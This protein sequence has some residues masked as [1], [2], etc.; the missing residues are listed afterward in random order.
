MNEAWQIP[1]TNSV[2]TTLHDHVARALVG[3]RL[4][5]LGVLAPRAH[6]VRITLAGLAFTTTVR[7]VD[8][9]HGLAAHGRADA[10]PALR[11]GLAVHA[12]VVLVVGHLANRGAAVDVHLAALARLQAQQRV[13]AFARGERGRGAG[14]AHHL[15]AL[16]GLELDVV[17]DR[18]D[19]D[20]AQ[21]H[22]VA[23]LDRRIRARAHFVAGGHAL[24]GEDVTALA[25]GVLHQRDVAGAVRIVLDAL[26]HALD[27]VLV[28]TEVDDAVLLLR[29]GALVA[30][31]DAA[32][33]VTARVL[34]LLL[35]QRLVRAALPE[36]R[37]VELDAEARARRSRLHLDD[38]HV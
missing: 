11:A 7:V 29:A 14:A 20:V 24:G 2:L 8:G 23:G 12:Q 25:V 21:L 31:R 22:A 10:Q 35:G 3:T 28:A 26:D 13:D 32:D 6:R 19:G 34:L 27:A 17:H 18:A 1:L 5:A 36:V 38:W 4:E 9:V 16:A 33:V 37:L 15:A 30:R